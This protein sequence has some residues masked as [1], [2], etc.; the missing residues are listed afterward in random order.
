MKTLTTIIK[1]QIAS[2]NIEISN[3]LA[4]SNRT[5]QEQELLGRVWEQTISL[6]VLL[7]QQK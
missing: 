1:E 5:Q 3:L 7:Q 6:L 4:N 2:N